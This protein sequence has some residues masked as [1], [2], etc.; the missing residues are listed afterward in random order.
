LNQSFNQKQVTDPQELG[1]GRA[2]HTYYRIDVRPPGAYSDPISSIRRRYSDFQW[3]FSRLHTEKPGAIIPIIPHT[4]AMQSAKR[5]SEELVEERRGHLERFLR[6][7]QVH[8]ELEGAPSLS[9]FFSADAEVF[10]A[11]KKENPVDPNADETMGETERLTE[12][13]KHFFVKTTVKAKVMRGA[14]LEETSD[15]R[16]IEEIEEYLNTVSVHVKSLSKTTLAL[17]KASEDTSTNM[18]ELGQV[19]F[20]SSIDQDMCSLCLS[21]ICFSFFDVRPCLASIKHMIQRTTQMAT[22]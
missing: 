16:Q 8:P 22:T 10:E 20:V 9:C 17:V 4:A 21:H 6:K 19:M 15:G 13:V 5:F 3:L 2:K 14:E 11:A 12:K 18:H 7:V 1:E